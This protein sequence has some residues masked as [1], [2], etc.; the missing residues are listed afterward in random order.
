VTYASNITDVDDKI[1]N[2]AIEE[3]I[4]EKEVAAKYAKAFFEVVEKIGAKPF[5]ETPHATEFIPEMIDFI[6]DLI[7]KGF[8]YQVPSGVYFD[9]SKLNE[10]G[11]LSNQKIEELRSSVRIDNETDKLDSVD[12]A[13]WKVTQ[14]GIKYDSPWGAG[15]PGWHTECVVMNN[16]LFNGE[17]LDIHG[18]GFDLKFPHHENEIAQSLAHDD[19]HLAKYWMHVGRLDLANIKMSKSLKN[20]V[21]IKDLLQHYDGNVYRLMLLAHHYRAPISY[22]SDLMEQY[23]KTYDKISYTLNKWNFQFILKD[24]KDDL[25]DDSIDTF[26]NYMDDDFNTPM[27]VTLLD[28]LVKELNKR[29]D[30]KIFNTLKTIL[31]VIGITPVVIEPTKDD[32]KNYMDWNEARLN[33]DFAKADTLR[34]LL[35]E[36][37]W[38]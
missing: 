11:V 28:S 21:K 29:E 37:G 14:E 2:R 5:D 20:D 4:S 9:V 36:K 25:M 8:A 16:K 10:Y 13:L 38:I 24:V 7:N 17:E 30:K 35:S 23:K 26:I 33:K 1:I 15:R 22:T 3:G 19:H 31:N 34:K 6:S 12:F 18:G 27:V 32:L